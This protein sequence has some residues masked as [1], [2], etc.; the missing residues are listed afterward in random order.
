MYEDWKTTFLVCLLYCT[1]SPI[2]LLFQYMRDGGG[3][4]HSLPDAADAHD[5]AVGPEGLHPH[6]AAAA[7]DA[8]AAL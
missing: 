5:G 8:S 1:S 3:S 4:E 6:P 2:G 7:G